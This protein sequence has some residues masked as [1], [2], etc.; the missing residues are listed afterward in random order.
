MCNRNV[1]QI[2][3]KEQGLGPERGKKASGPRQG[4]R[5]IRGLH[6]RCRGILGGTQV[7]LVPCRTQI[8]SE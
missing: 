3:G 6:K 8:S 1:D 7:R 4:K 5:C 2:Q